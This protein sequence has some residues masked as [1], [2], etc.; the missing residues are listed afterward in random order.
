MRELPLGPIVAARAQEGKCPSPAQYQSSNPCP[1]PSPHPA[2]SNGVYQPPLTFR[3]STFARLAV[4]YW[5]M[6]MRDA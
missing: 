2:T 3:Y 4:L 5:Y 6:L 1:D